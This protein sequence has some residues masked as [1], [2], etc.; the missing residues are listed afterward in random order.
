MRNNKGDSMFDIRNWAVACL[1]AATLSGI[2]AAAQPGS[3]EINVAGGAAFPTQANRFSDYAKSGPAG[4]IQY[5]Y[6]WDE[7]MAFGVQADYY[8]FDGKNHLLTSDAGGQ[9][10]ALSTDNVG[11]LE[12]M[13]RYT[14]V[15]GARFEP[16]VHSGLGINYFHQTSEGT[17]AAGSTWS[18]T[19]TTETRQLQ[20]VSTVGVSYSIGIGVETDL[21]SNLVLGLESAWHIFSVSKAA[22]GTNTIDVPT[23]TMR[24]GW[25]FGPKATMM[26]Q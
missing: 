6:H 14:F 17:P 25:R 13:G 22:Y 10:D 12:I 15:P 1:L 16:Y 19:N 18:D 9:V 11:T 2:A 24:L 20:D 4:G 23:V 26:D 5:L 7:T 21:T 8:H 3:Q